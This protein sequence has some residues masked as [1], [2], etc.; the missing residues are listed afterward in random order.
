MTDVVVVW[1]GVS[2]MCHADTNKQHSTAWGRWGRR[3]SHTHRACERD[4]LLPL[5]HQHKQAATS[6][7]LFARGRWCGCVKHAS[8]SPSP[9]TLPTHLIMKQRWRRGKGRGRG[10]AS[11]MEGETTSSANGC[12]HSHKA[13]QL[14]CCACTS[15]VGQRGRGEKE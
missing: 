3:C 11:G 2:S 8:L 6:L 7:Q 14:H 10:R 1:L 5:S 4:T 9:H 12:N 15:R 13:S